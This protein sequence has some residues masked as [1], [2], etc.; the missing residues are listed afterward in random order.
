VAVLLAAEFLLLGVLV[1]IALHASLYAVEPK[2]P[3]AV[4]GQQAGQFARVAAG[5]QPQAAQRL[6][7]Y[8]QQAAGYGPNLGLPDSE[9][10]RLEGLQGVILEVDQQEEELLGRAFQKG[11]AVFSE[12]GVLARTAWKGLVAVVLL[13]ERLEIAQQVLEFDHCQAGQQ[14]EFAL[15]FFLIFVVHAV[16]FASGRVILNNLSK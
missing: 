13:P 10:G 4:A 16:K 9:A 7:E 1:S 2:D 15:V 3:A 8:R 12:G 6:V 5:Q 14:Q 11:V